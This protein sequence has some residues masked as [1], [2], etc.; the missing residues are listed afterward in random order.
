MWFNIVSAPVFIIGTASLANG[1]L[2]NGRANVQTEQCS[3]YETRLVRVLVCVVL[4]CAC[5]M[6]KRVSRGRPL[7]AVV[8]ADTI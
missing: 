2:C 6:G 1:D 7:P 3:G 4:G 5:R 8:C